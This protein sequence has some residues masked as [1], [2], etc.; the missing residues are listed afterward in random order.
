[1]F[2]LVKDGKTIKVADETL[3]VTLLKK[4]YMEKVNPNEELKA[5]NKD[6]MN[7]IESLKDELKR[8]KAEVENLTLENMRLKDEL[9]VL[10]ANVPAK[11]GK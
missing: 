3:K 10:S 1:M 6:L 11:N 8:A 4:G 2:E 7:E 5:E 9:Q